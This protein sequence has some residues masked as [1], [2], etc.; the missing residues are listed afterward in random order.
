MQCTVSLSLLSNF[1]TLLLSLPSFTAPFSSFPL[2]VPPFLS[3]LSLSLLSLPSLPLLSLPPYRR[4]DGMYIC[5]WTMLSQTRYALCVCV[6]VLCVRV[7]RDMCMCSVLCVCILCALCVC[8]ESDMCVCVSS[9]YLMSYHAFLPASTPVAH[10]T[11]HVPLSP[12]S[13]PS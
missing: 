6:Y 2:S 9:C 8:D 13:T 11:L 5:P 10:S 12:C 3:L 4:L 1:V 7:G